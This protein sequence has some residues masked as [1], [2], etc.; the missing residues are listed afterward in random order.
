MARSRFVFWLWPTLVG[1]LALACAEAEPVTEAPAGPPPPPLP[2]KPPAP[3]DG[4]MAKP[5]MGGETPAPADPCAGL[6]FEGRCD[7][8]LAV[9]C[10]DGDVRSVDCAAYGTQCAWIDPVTGYYCE[11]QAPEAAPGPEADE[12][13]APKPP[14]SGGAPESSPSPAPGPDP[15]PSPSPDPS[16]SPGPS[17]DPSPSPSPSPEKVPEGNAD[18]SPAPSPSPSPS[19]SPEPSPSPSPEPSPSPSPEPGPGGDACGSE[20][21]EGR[22]EGDTA[23]WCDGGRV[24]RFDCRGRLSAGCGWVDAETG[25]FCRP[26]DGGAPAPQPQPE[27]QP[28]PQPEPQPQPQ[29]EPQ[30]DPV[31]QPEPDPQPEPGP[32]PQPEPAPEPDDPCGGLDYLGRCAGDVAE[33]CDDDRIRQHDCGSQGMTCGYIDDQVGYFCVDAPAPQPEPQPQPDPQPDPG[34]CGGV[35]ELGECRGDVAVWCDAG[36]LQQIDC[37]TMGQSCGWTGDAFG[38]SCQDGAP[39]PA[40]E[41]DPQPDGCAGVDFLGECRGDV[42][43]WCADG[44]LRELNCLDLGQ[45]CGWVDDATGYYCQ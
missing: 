18:P 30:P 1:A 6:G 7:G 14:E 21:Y 23:V 42:A 16:P 33:W 35:D 43:V 41:P 45:S 5:P 10:E 39:E 32:D 24:A 34:G 29:P 9:W 31:P 19:P 4:P 27:P 20:S 3:E 37:A 2:E 22:C 11:A 17:P 15:S 44:T 13:E 36:A 28:Q 8:D 12:E 40:P 25:Y 26:D 38:Y